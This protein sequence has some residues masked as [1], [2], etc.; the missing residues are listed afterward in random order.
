MI[1]EPLRS[2][3]P[4][5][6]VVRPSS[7]SEATLSSLL[8]YIKGNKKFI[9]D[10]RLKNG[11]ILFRDFD[12]ENASDFEQVAHLIH[13]N[14][15][16]G[17]LGVTART[18]R[19]KYVFT[20]T[21]VTNIAPIGQHTEMAYMTNR[22]NRIFF[23][24]LKEPKHGG[25]TPI[26]DMRQVVLDADKHDPNLLKQFKAHGLT[27]YRNYSTPGTKVKDIAEVRSWPDIYKTT[28]KTEVEKVCAKDDIECIWHGDALSLVSKFPAIRK[29][30]ETGD[31]V[32]SNA[33]PVFYPRMRTYEF[34]K[35]IQ[36]IGTW[37]YYLMYLL[38]IVIESL[39]R[40]FI[41][42]TQ[43]GLYVTYGNGVPIR[44]EELF[45]IEDIIWDNM[46]T[47]KWKKGDVIYID[48]DRVSHGRLP[49][50]GQR[51][52]V[53]ALGMPDVKSST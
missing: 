1:V 43:C 41:P 15:N 47:F 24:C 23:C 12:I 18:N 20:S 42:D 14:L 30:P 51:Q 6:I 16:D 36:T 5:P 48:N 38:W 17:Y 29:H 44:T 50:F 37:W 35:M 39:R 40:L 13:P 25:E 33:V 8:G 9:E 27:Y 2:D 19:T 10:T 7:K 32:W 31:E 22:P 34:R 45:K 26:T 49:Y 46:V 3:R 11:A 28:D 53:C 21:E 4:I 52:I